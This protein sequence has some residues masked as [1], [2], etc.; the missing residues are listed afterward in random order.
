[1]NRKR[2]LSL[3]AFAL[4]STSPLSAKVEIFAL[5]AHREG[6]ITYLQKPVVLYKN[7]ELQ[8][9]RGKIINRRKIVLEGNVT[10]FRDNY[11]LKGNRLVAYSD[12][13]ITIENNVFFYDQKFLTWIKGDMGKLKGNNVAFKGV[14]FSTCCPYKPEWHFYAN[15]GVY[16]RKRRY[17]KLYNVTLYLGK[18]PILYLPWLEFPTDKRRRT[19]L[20]R[21]YV[22]FSQ[23]EGLLYSQPF[24]IVTSQHTDLT[25]TPTIRT[26][27][28]KGLFFDFRFMD[29]PYSHGDIF[30]GEF[31]DKNEYYNKYD[32]AHKEHY[33]W[34]FKYTRS[35]VFFPDRDSLYA[36]IKY[37]NDVDY[38]YLN[39]KNYTF[40]KKYL[41]DKVIDSKLNYLY[42][43]NRFAVGVY[44]QYYID[45]TKPTNRNTW[46]TIPQL[47]YHQFPVALWNHF[48]I[49]GDLNLYNYWTSGGRSAKSGTLYLPI[50]FYTPLLNHFL[51]LKF[52]QTFYGGRLAYDGDPV[53]STGTNPPPAS[54]KIWVSTLQVYS[55]LVKGYG[56]WVHAITPQITITSK[57]YQKV[58]DNAPDLLPVPPIDNAITFQIYQLLEGGNWEIEDT[59]S[60]PYLPASKEWGD[61]KNDFKF[62]L[63]KFSLEDKYRYSARDKKTTY[64]YIKIGYNS[65]FEPGWGGYISHLYD[66]RNNLKTFTYNIQY[67]VSHKKGYYWEESLDLNQHYIKYWLFGIKFN[68]KRCLKYNISYKEAR[69]PV[70]KESGIS[71]LKDRIISF[72][73]ELI[74]LGGVNQTFILK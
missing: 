11:V 71:Y 60:R 63:D 7:G 48:L 10:L 69:T 45:T 27:R 39:P 6:N 46:Q 22:G 1:V 66:Y 50:T 37:A 49:S 44:N 59:L 25:I 21:P 2:L 43:T 51:N 64:H 58:E 67:W 56:S 36:D 14:E 8:A 29:S 17:L 61:L 5:S 57:N 28:G 33:G 72:S 31:W 26:L 13:N 73:I 16:Y 40:D 3:I 35:R 54:Y 15:S 62:K 34:E 74:P 55:N 32:L 47:N 20:L 52:S 70:L 30:F 65:E 68:N 19:G 24:F 41:T 53:D 18:A 42:Q 23:R 4:F 12:K 38:F 9:E